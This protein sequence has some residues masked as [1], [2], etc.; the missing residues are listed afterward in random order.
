MRRANIQRLTINEP[1][2]SLLYSGLDEII[3]DIN[4]LMFNFIANAW[5]LSGNPMK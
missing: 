2:L 4:F 3:R 5:F 1:I